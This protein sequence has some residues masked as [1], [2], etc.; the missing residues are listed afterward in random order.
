MTFQDPGSYVGYLH[1]EIQFGIKNANAYYN[2]IAL[3]QSSG[4]GKSRAVRELSKLNY[5]I[6]LFCF[7]SNESSGFPLKTPKSNDFLKE[8][9][10]CENA[11]DVEKLALLWISVSMQ[12]KIQL[13]ESSE[14]SE[15]ENLHHFCSYCPQ[16]FNNSYLLM[17]HI[18]DD[19]LRKNGISE[20]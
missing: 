3:I 20:D 15:D 4:Y 13:Q 7:R 6:L 12:R 8:L 18:E 2:Y 10:E 1:E 9:H 16:T 14:S 5:W 11:D 19:H 17:K